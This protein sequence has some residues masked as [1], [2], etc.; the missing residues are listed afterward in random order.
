MMSKYNHFMFGTNCKDNQTELKTIET[1]QLYE[2]ISSSTKELVDSTKQLRSV[3]RYSKERYRSMK[4]SL[5][6][7]SCSHFDPPF[8]SYKNFKCAYG[9]II[10]IDDD[11]PI[12]PL[13]IHRFRADPRIIMGY[14]S[15]SNMG[16]KLIFQFDFP[17]FDANHYVNVY[18]TF[19][20]Q[21]SYE[22]HITDKIDKRNSD[23]GRISFICHDPNAW[24]NTD[25][26]AID[27][28][29]LIQQSSD[30]ETND[31]P[32][33]DQDPIS[34]T[35]YKQILTL[36]DT[37]PKTPKIIAPVMEEIQIIMPDI[38]Q[39]L[40][41]YDIEIK[42]TSSIQ[43]GAKIRIY[44][45]VHIGEINLYKGKQGYKVVTSPRKGTHFELNE[46]AMH[47]IQQALV[48]Y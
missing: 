39:A 21:F 4:T 25:F 38:R 22:Y 34:P 43:Y 15:P 29:A 47:I 35:V 40:M 8:R 24:L 5:P 48:K 32:S 26:I 46:A 13:L 12:E 1:E 2:M 11:K 7:F 19:I 44:K 9:M 17:V 3:L 31:T 14:I 45:D 42:D 33:Q 18:K 6:F 10:D 36:L 20:M 23:V 30:I 41:S 16:M 37:K 27:W 28:K